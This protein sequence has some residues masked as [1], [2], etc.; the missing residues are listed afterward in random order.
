M[1]LTRDWP[2]SSDQAA[3]VVSTAKLIS[4]DVRALAIYPSNQPSNVGIVVTAVCTERC[5]G[6]S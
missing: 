4:D 5:R 1:A 3:L 6:V 2:C